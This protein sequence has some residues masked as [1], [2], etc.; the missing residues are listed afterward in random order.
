MTMRSL[1]C[2]ERCSRQYDVTYVKRGSTLACECG[3]RFKVF[4]REPHAPKA[5]RCSS[6]GAALR[7]GSLRCEYCTSEVTIEEKHLSSVCPKCYARLTS[8]ARFCLECGVA[9][10]PQSLAAIPEG[11]RCPRCASVLRGRNV[12]ELSLIECS[13]CA[14]LWLEPNALESLCDQADQQS[15]VS[16]FLQNRPAPAQ[17]VAASDVRYLACIRCDDRMVRRNFGQT[18]G[19]ILDHC[20]AHGVWLDHS[21]LDKILQF[22]KGGGLA[23]GRE[24][25]LEAL[26]AERSRA[27]AARASRFGEPAGRA[28]LELSEDDLLLRALGALAR[29]LFR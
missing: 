5:M 10:A 4:H 9:I 11:A 25:E 22:V 12:R 6:C 19:I 3:H 1:L 16:Q 15:L 21:E 14:G 28:T 18:S 26:A 24:R 17:Q 20:R 27:A 13:S 7:E 2:C 29:K 8:D 23:K